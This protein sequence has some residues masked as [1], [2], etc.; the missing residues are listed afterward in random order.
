[1]DQVDL[2]FNTPDEARA[3]LNKIRRNLI[4]TRDAAQKT[5]ETTFD[6]LAHNIEQQVQRCSNLE[7]T[8]QTLQLEKLQLNAA[9]NTFNGHIIEFNGSTRKTRSGEQRVCKLSSPWERRWEPWHKG[10]N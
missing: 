7:G 3:T 1:M 9:L 10:G 6:Y 2:S 4:T 8:V 5:T